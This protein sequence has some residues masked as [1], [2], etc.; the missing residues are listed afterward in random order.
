VCFILREPCR[1]IYIQHALI[2]WAI[3][4]CTTLFNIESLEKLIENKIQE[5]SYSWRAHLY[6]TLHTYYL[7]TTNTKVDMSLVVRVDDERLST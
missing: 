3:R 7:S 6:T 2:V 5:T 1:G 4:A